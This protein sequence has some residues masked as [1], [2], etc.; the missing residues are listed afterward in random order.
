MR[1]PLLIQ[2]FS[3]MKNEKNYHDFLK[4]S[5]VQGNVLIIFEGLDEVP[6]HIDRSDLMKEINALLERGIDYDPKLGKLRYSIY[7]QKEINNTKNPTI[8]NRFIITSRIEGNYFEDINFYVPRL[9]IEDM[10]NEA[11]KLFCRSYMECIKD[12]SFQAGRLVKEHTTD[13]LYIDI[14]QN[15]D[16]LQLAINPQLASVIAAI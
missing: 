3:A 16:I 7:E 9:S 8:G 15:K 4:E 6:A 5:L 11:L 14:T 12:I 10:S 1:I 2:C 13:Q